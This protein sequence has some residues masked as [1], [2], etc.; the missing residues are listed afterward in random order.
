M[1]S[2][3]LFVEELARTVSEMFVAGK[4]SPRYEEIVKQYYGTVAYG[5]STEEDARKKLA[6]IKVILE[7]D[8]KL[9]C[10]LVGNRFY[11][12]FR[13]KVPNTLADAR[14]C[15]PLG[16]GNGAQGI[17]LCT[18]VDDLIWQAS[19]ELNVTSGAR[20][21]QK[22]FDDVTTAIANGRLT[23]EKAGELLYTGMRNVAPSD[24]PAAGKAIGAYL[25]SLESGELSHDSR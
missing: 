9:Q 5:G 17:H 25:E 12:V 4:H 24:E 7:R 1:A 14:L 10:C 8:Y 6:R 3:R 21:A 22:S 18:G 11:T 13:R 23:K 16:N 15:L 20:K 19:K 2:D